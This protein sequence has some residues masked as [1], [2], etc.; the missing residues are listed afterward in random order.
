MAPAR[1][2]KWTWALI[3]GGLLTLG[4]GFAVQR[5]DAALGCGLIIAGA[6]AGAAGGV[7]IWVR[8]RMKDGD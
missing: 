5:N 8:S 1:V 6:V 3:F 4:L 7:L 2:E